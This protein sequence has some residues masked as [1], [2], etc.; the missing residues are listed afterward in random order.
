MLRSGLRLRVVVPGQQAV[1]RNRSV[2]AGAAGADRSS[3][4]TPRPCRACIR[5]IR[6]CRF[7]AKGSSACTGLSLTLALLLA[8]LSAL[9]LAIVF[10]ER[11]SAPLSILA[12]GTRAVAQGDFS[13]RHPVRSHD[14]LGVLTE[15]FNTMTTQLAEARTQVLRNQEQ[16]EAAK[17]YLESILAKLSAG[18]LSFDGERRLR[19]ANPSAE[20]IL[21]VELSALIG[22]AC[23]RLGRPGC[24]A[25]R[26]RRRHRRSDRRGRQ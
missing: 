18:V 19:S 9:V 13:Q 17:A 25:G 11:L 21:G 4:V 20:Q 7:R 22:V 24:A 1:G 23:E 14:E 2:A 26:A 3:R 12:A 16:L 8:L 15:S 6:S 5:I 10:S